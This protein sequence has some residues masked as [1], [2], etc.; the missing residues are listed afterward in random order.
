MNIINLVISLICGA[1]GGNVAG[2]A[3]KD[4]SLGTTGNSIAGIL[5]GGIGG[6]ILQL[7]GFSGG[8]AAASGSGIDWT[9]VLSSVGSG[10]IGGAVLLIIVSFIKNAMMKK[11]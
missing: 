8:G 5:G 7:L 2:V 3:M 11:T 9:Q 4:K 6:F 1:V 10:G